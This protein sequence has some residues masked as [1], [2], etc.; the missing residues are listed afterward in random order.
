ME[1]RAFALRQSRLSRLLHQHVLQRLG[2]VNGDTITSP[3]DGVC[4]ATGG[5]GGKGG[6]G[7]E[8]G[9]GGSG[10]KFGGK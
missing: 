9:S 2:S 3:V 10:G 7:D 5:E 1:L 8:G 4:C 6:E